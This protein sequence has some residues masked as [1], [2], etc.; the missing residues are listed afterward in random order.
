MFDHEKMSEKDQIRYAEAMQASIDASKRPQVT[1]E[2]EFIP[3]CGHSVN[4]EAVKAG[5]TFDSATGN[6][7]YPNDLGAVVT[8]PP[9]QWE[10]QFGRGERYEYAKGLKV[11]S[12]VYDWKVFN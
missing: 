5:K 1:E 2:T 4:P 8:A 7:C 9:E 3:N 12:I 11:V 10:D 6:W